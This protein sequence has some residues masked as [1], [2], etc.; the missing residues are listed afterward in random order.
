LKIFQ[1][2]DSANKIREGGFKREAQGYILTHS[3]LGKRDRGGNGAVIVQWFFCLK[4]KTVATSAENMSA[5]K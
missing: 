5:K 2:K 3:D 1:D 4:K